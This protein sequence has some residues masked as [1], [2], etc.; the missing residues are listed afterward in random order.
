MHNSVKLLYEVNKLRKNNAI[1]CNHSKVIPIFE[2]F[3]GSTFD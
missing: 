2:R 3:Y 1:L